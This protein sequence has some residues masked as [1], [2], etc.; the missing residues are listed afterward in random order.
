VLVDFWDLTA[1]AFVLTGICLEHE[2]HE[3][4][5]LALVVN[6]TV[7][8]DIL[9]EVSNS[10]GDGTLGLN[11]L[12]REGSDP[13]EQLENEHSCEGRLFAAHLILSPPAV[14]DLDSLG[15]VTDGIEVVTKSDATD[16][17]HSGAGGIFDD[18][19]LEGSVAGSM[20]L[21]RNAGLESGGDLVDVGVHFANIVRR[22]GGGNETTHAL[23]VL[24]TLDPDERTAAEADDEGTENGRMGIIVRVFCVDVGETDGITHNQL[25]DIRQSTLERFNDGGRGAHDVWVA[26]SGFHLESSTAFVEPGAPLPALVVFKLGLFV[27][28]DERGTSLRGRIGV[29][30]EW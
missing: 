14:G 3:V 16:D 17:V 8:N 28:P 18:V 23:V 22:K 13:R 12:E 1:L 27:A 24:L 21:V 19:E 26:P 2:G 6:V 25:D 20:D 4:L 29:S 5:T 11:G 9:G 15:G 30:G 7:G 10:I